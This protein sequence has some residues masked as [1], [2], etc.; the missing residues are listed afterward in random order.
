MMSDQIL[1]L[2]LKVVRVTVKRKSINLTQC[3]IHPINHNNDNVSTGK[4]IH[5]KQAISKAC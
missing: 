4:I 1:I 2:L 3:S 5:I